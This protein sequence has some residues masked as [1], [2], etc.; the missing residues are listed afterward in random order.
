MNFACKQSFFVLTCTDCDKFGGVEVPIRFT[1]EPGRF[2]KDTSVTG[3][4]IS[5]NLMVECSVP[6]VQIP[7]HVMAFSNQTNC[8]VIFA[9]CPDD[10]P[11]VPSCSVSLGHPLSMILGIPGNSI[12][13]SNF[14]PEPISHFSPTIARQG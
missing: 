7:P 3:S 9:R 4:G 14:E 6:H 10:P 13:P 12:F 5:V 2:L 8:L 11:G 1:R